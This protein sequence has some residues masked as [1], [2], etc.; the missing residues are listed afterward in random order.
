MCW[1]RRLNREEILKN[2]QQINEIDSGDSAISDLDGDKYVPTE[3]NNSDDESQISSQHNSECHENNNSLDNDCSET[4]PQVSTNSR[5]K[6]RCTTGLFSGTNRKRSRKGSSP[7]IPLS[8]GKEEI[9]KD[10][11]VWKEISPSGTE[12]QCAAQNIVKE[13]KGP[14]S[15]AKRNICEDGVLRS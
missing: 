3:S 4:N 9:S 15:Y 10:G 12:D 7:N 2:L 1:A 14:T 11:T 6:R 13:T 5:Q 8:V